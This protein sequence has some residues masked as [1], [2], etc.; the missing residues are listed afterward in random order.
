MCLRL[1]ATPSSLPLIATPVPVNCFSYS[2]CSFGSLKKIVMSVG[3]TPFSMSMAT[4][5]SAQTTGLLYDGIAHCIVMV[6]SDLLKLFLWVGPFQLRTLALV[7]F[8][9]LLIGK[10][11]ILTLRSIRC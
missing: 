7:E 11:Y 9:L 3:L 5:D 4:V 10:A 6:V 2:L 1:L 8:L